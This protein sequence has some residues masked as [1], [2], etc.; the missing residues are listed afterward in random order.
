MSGILKITAVLLFLF[1]G[2][3]GLMLCFAIVQQVFG[4]F[5]AILSIFLLPFLLGLAPWYVLFANGDFMPLLV[6]YG[7]GIPAIILFMLSEKFEK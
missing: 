7:G 2:F 6:V 1:A 5:V 3:Y 4:T